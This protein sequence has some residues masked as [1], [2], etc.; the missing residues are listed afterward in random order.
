MS[1]LPLGRSPIRSLHPGGDTRLVWNS[2]ETATLCPLV[3]DRDRWFLVT[4]IVSTGM[5]VHN[6]L[7]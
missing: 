3:S 6:T 7:V 1:H 5:Q 2:D 4:G